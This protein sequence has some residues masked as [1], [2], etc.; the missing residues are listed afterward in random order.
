MPSQKP[1]PAEPTEPPATAATSPPGSVRLMAVRY[2]DRQVV[3][4][5]RRGQVADL[6]GVHLSTVDRLVTGGELGCVR[7]RRRVL[8]S[9]GDLQ[10]LVGRCRE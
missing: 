5:M 1:D 2:R 9:L 10:D 8:F 7:V 3:S 6:L 4:L